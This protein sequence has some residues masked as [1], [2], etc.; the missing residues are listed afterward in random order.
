VTE[1]V[2]GRT[3]TALEAA[4][5]LRRPPAGEEPGSASERAATV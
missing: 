1:D 5:A 4:G 2:I 3:R